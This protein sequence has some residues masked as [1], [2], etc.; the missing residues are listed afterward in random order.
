MVTALDFT[1]KLR[2][3]KIERNISKGGTKW[4]NT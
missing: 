3:A 1:D 4:V 2:K